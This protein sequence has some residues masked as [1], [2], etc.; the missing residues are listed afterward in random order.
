MLLATIALTLAAGVVTLDPADLRPGQTGICVTEWTGG[1]R[2]EMGVEVLGTLDAAGPERTYVLVRLLDPE[3]AGAGVVAG[4]SGSPVYLDGK[5]LGAVA[6]GWAFAREP[7]AGVTPFG[8]MERMPMPGPASPPP[9]PT[10]QQLIALATGAGDPLA[11]APRLPEVPE[12]GSRMLAVA[13]L[14]PADGFARQMLTRVGLEAVPAAGRTDLTGVPGPGDMMAALLVWGDAVVAAGGTVTAVAGDRIFAFG[15]PLFNL[16]QTSLP[17]TRARVLAIQS[18]YQSSFKL[19]AVGESFGTLVADRSPGVIARIGDAPPG[20][21]LTVQVR[22][23]SGEATWHFKVA[24]SPLLA[25][26]MVTYLSNSCL[27]ARG[28]ATGEASVHLRVTV[29][30]S[31]GRRVALTQAMRGFDALARAASFTGGLVATLAASS[32]PH[33]NLDAVEVFLEREE[34]IRSAVIAEVVPARTTVHPGEELTIEVR[35]APHRGERRSQQLC[36]P[37]PETV[38]VG[39]LDL[40]VADGAAWT[41]YR[42]RTEPLQP[43]SFTDL[44]DVL[45]MLE[46]STTLVAVLE[47]REPGVALSGGVMP[48]LPPSWALTLTTGLGKSAVPRLGTAVLASVRW[49]APCP[50]EGAF[51]LP[52]TV[53]PR[54]ETP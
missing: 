37:I 5:L 45:G 20:L 4:M 42:L 21:P 33:P 9:P 43:R 26:L 14:P 32:F 27:T 18:S 7:L 44:L 3:L 50:L 40:I 25:P 34:L 46:A 53:R 13:G 23:V 54:L 35:L 29:T 1:Q 48:A 39:A 19:F 52:L 8:L 17:A 51:R 38:P 28:A 47:S 41:D 36:I 30:L 10:L 12:R 2:R 15:H 16:G 24:E 31:D 11:V 22:D 49:H 6:I